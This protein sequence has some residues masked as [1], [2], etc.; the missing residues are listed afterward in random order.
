VEYGKFLS[1]SG[2]IKDL[3]VAKGLLRPFG[4]SPG[5]HLKELGHVE[6]EG[7]AHRKPQQILFPPEKEEEERRE[8]S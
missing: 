2:R 4:P 7:E 8:P 3:T 1:I 6:Q 5:P